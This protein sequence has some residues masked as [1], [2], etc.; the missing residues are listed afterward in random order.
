MSVTTHEVFLRTLAA[1]ITAF[2]LNPVFTLDALEISLQLA[3]KLQYDYPV[4]TLSNGY[5]LPYYTACGN[6]NVPDRV[7]SLRTKLEAFKQQN[8]TAEAILEIIIFF[9]E[10]NKTHWNTGGV[11]MVFVAHL[12]QAACSTLNLQL[13]N[14]QLV[15][16]KELL[17]N[18]PAFLRAARGDY[19]RDE[20]EA[21]EQLAIIQSATVS[22]SEH[23][24]EQD[25]NE[26]LKSNLGRRMPI[27]DSNVL[28]VAAP[29][30]SPQ[31]PDE[32]G[33][34]RDE[35]LVASTEPY[36]TAATSTLV[37]RRS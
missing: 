8:Q 24:S 23:Q 36:P 2:F 32:F 1:K 5:L 31:P 12:A 16:A 30:P 17:L 13:L 27:G 14:E 15:G 7:H 26:E 25:H 22:L 29:T 18:F 3:Q 28:T 10:A 9:I 21:T 19:R 37:Q 6:R 34:P 33:D 11:N 4:V 35:G 20:A